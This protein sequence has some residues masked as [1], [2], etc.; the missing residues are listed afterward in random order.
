MSLVP[1]YTSLVM[2]VLAVNL[3]ESVLNSQERNCRRDGCTA[4]MLLAVTAHCSK[5]DP[6]L[7]HI[8]LE[9]G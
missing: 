1:I 3:T 7:Y 6:P 9:D 5:R 4:R 2:I 8:R